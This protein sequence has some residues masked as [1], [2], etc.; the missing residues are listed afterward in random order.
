MPRTSYNNNRYV[1][2]NNSSNYIDGNQATVTVN[3]IVIVVAV[4]HFKEQR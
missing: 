1:E 2:C 4:T 3:V